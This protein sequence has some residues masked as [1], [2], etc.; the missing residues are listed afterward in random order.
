MMACLVT[1]M[2]EPIRAQMQWFLV[3]PDNSF[4]WIAELLTQ[5]T[6]QSAIHHHLQN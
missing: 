4:T 1:L 2:R 6:G 3:L 5:Y